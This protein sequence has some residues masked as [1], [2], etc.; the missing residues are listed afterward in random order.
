MKL[1]PFRGLPPWFWPWY[2][3]KLLSVT[4]RVPL[5]VEVS[6]G[7]RLVSYTLPAAVVLTMCSCGSQA[8]EDGVELKGVKKDSGSWCLLESRTHT[9]Q[10]HVPYLVAPITHPW[11]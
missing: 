3:S 7:S 9:C 8:L 6:V 1:L 4:S 5:V 11:S 10:T 2:C